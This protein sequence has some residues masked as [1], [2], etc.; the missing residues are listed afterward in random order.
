MTG[1]NVETPVTDP[2]GETLIERVEAL[3]ADNARLRRITTSLFIGAGVLVGLLLALVVVTARRGFPGALANVVESNS[4]VVKD[5]DGNVRGAWGMAD[6]GSSRLVLQNAQGQGSLTLTLLPDG[7]PGVSFT[8]SAG[9]SRM[10]LGLLPD[11]TTTLVFA[12][13]DGR[14]RT[15]LGLAPDGSSSLAFAD[16][17]GSTRAGL[18]LDTRGIGT[19]TL[20]ERPS[21]SGQP[22]PSVV[23]AADS[24]GDGDSAS[25]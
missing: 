3:E 6:D 24:A 5:D 2:A 18:G 9:Q 25:N 16:E 13:R 17:D 11:Q 19:F 21:G 10:V 22:E 7:S 8:D 12:D 14:T 23:E 20:A 4:F 15:V 1:S